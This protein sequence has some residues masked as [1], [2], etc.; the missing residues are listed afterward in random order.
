MLT[1]TCKYVYL[2]YFKNYILHSTTLFTHH[3]TVPS[4]DITH[5][6]ILL[7]I[8]DNIYTS[9][10]LKQQYCEKAWAFGKSCVNNINY[11]RTGAPHLK[12]YYG[13]LTVKSEHLVIK[14]VHFLY[15]K[16]FAGTIS[17]IRK[18]KSVLRSSCIYK[19]QQ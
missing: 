15:N 14:F 4:I 6:N 9:N 18:S 5:L 8:E 11:Q 1:N 7:K 3:K 17:W 13:C 12:K 19:W 2:L 10:S 16:S